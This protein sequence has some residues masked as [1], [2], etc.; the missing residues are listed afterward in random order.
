MITPNR[1]E[2]LV[3]ADET[4]G[5]ALDILSALGQFNASRLVRPD[6]TVVVKLTP[7][8]FH[9]VGKMPAGIPED[10]ARVHVRLASIHV[11]PP[12]VAA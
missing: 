11:E 2:F 5:A 4:S 10:A 8:S 9:V 12:E 7:V 3:T 6:G 1:I